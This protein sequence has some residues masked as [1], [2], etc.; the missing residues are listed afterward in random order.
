[1]HNQ[2]LFIADLIRRHLPEV[3]FSITAVS[4]M[5]AHPAINNFVSRVTQRFHWLVRY[6]IFVVVC[7]AGYGAIMQIIYRS[8]KHWL[9]Y[10]RSLALIAITVVVYLALAFFAKKQGHI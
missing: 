1:M 7:T 10:Q 4:L 9:S 8:L 5:L 3:C 2:I 6:L